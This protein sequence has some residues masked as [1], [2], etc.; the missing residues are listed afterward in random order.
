[1]PVILRG[2]VCGLQSP[3][4]ADSCENFSTNLDA[5]LTAKVV[6]EL[7]DAAIRGDFGDGQPGVKAM[8]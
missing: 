1:M 6:K 7:T 5:W 4:E 2:N 8:D 3:S